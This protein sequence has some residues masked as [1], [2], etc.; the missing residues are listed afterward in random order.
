MGRPVPLRTVE[1]L[2]V[3]QKPS[4]GGKIHRSKEGRIL[5]VLQKPSIVGKTP[6]SKEGKNPR[7]TAETLYRWENPS[8]YGG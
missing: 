1:T 8:L 5:E 4:I 3:R 2:K 6:P 7:S